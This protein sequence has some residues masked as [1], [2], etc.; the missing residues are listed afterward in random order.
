VSTVHTLCAPWFCLPDGTATA[1]LSCTWQDGYSILYFQTVSK[2]DTARAT[3]KC[4]FVAKP[5]VGFFLLEL[6][7]DLSGQTADVEMGPAETV[8]LQMQAASALLDMQQA[9]SPDQQQHLSNLAV[10]PLSASP[11]ASV[12]RLAR[13][14]T[15][16]QEELAQT[17]QDSDTSAIMWTQQAMAKLPQ[18][19][20]DAACGS[21]RM[22]ALSTAS[23]LSSGLLA[24][25]MSAAAGPA[26]PSY[27][28]PNPLRPY[29]FEGD[30]SVVSAQTCRHRCFPSPTCRCGSSPLPGSLLARCW[31]PLSSCHENST[32]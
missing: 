25:C 23:P 11:F 17:V 19:S 4:K 22:S 12:A 18:I 28:A 32:M 26:T 21:P 9:C 14:S 31:L 20:V 15:P 1:P 10:S 16:A 29:T 5:Q 30:A 7:D 6:Q 27:G 24:Q 3:I 13:Q 2:N 8:L